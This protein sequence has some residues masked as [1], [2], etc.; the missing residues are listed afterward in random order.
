MDIVGCTCT[1]KSECKTFKCQCLATKTLYSDLCACKPTQCANRKL[2]PEKLKNL[3][4]EHEVVVNVQLGQGVQ[5][6]RL[7]LGAR[8]A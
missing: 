4:Q 5:S 6:L 7:D 8:K 1:G 2:P 3:P